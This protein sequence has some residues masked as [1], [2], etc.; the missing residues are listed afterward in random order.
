MKNTQEE[1]FCYCLSNKE[2]SGQLCPFIM[3]N[4]QRALKINNNVTFFTK[5]FFL[6][7]EKKLS[8]CSNKVGFTEI[9]LF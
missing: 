9:K 8:V 5:S 6:I 3:N 1:N 4:G 7:G 2:A